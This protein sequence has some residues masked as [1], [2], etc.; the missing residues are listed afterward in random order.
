[1]LAT[2]V[3]LASGVAKLPIKQ[4]TRSRDVANSHRVLLGF[5]FLSLKAEDMKTRAADR[6]KRKATSRTA[7]VQAVNKLSSSKG[8]QVAGIP[9]DTDQEAHEVLRATAPSPSQKVYMCISCY[10][11]WPQLH[12][13][14]ILWHKLS[15]H[16]ACAR[17]CASQPDCAGGGAKHAVL[18]CANR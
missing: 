17:L 12:W 8:K 4:T 5:V 6:M 10:L 15:C 11:A 9:V 7:P 16:D 18:C 2:P 1:M 14:E 3:K 13:H